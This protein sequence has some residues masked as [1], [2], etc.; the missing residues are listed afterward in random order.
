MTAA[1]KL[2]D[3]LSA[4]GCNPRQTGPSQWS[5]KCPV[6]GDKSPSMSVGVGKDGAVLTCRVGCDVKL[7]VEAVGLQLSDL[8]DQ[9][10]QKGQRR[11]L[12]THDYIDENDELLYQTVRFEGTGDDRFRQ[13]RPDGKG[14][15]IW[16]LKDTRRVLYNLPAV[17][18]AIEAGTVILAAEGEHDADALIRA[19]TVATTNPLGAANWKPEYTAQ[20]AGANV[21]LVIDRDD[22]GRKRA[23][24]LAAE[25]EGAGG[26]TIVGIYEPVE[27]KD[28]AEVL[29]MGYDLDTGFRAVDLDELATEANAQV[30][31]VATPPT[32]KPGFYFKDKVGLLAAK[33]ADDIQAI[34]P[35]AYGVDNI[36]WSYR[37]GVWRPDPR[38]VAHRATTL[39]GDRYRRSHSVNAEDIIRAQTPKITCDP[40]SEV[41]NFRN[42]LYLWQADLLRDHTPDM[43]TTV[44]LSVDW[45][46]DATCPAFDKFLGEVVPED[47]VALVWEAIGYLLYS[48]NPLHR[49]Y[50]LMGA[51]RNGKG[52]L[53]RV[54]GALIGAANY[55]AVSLHSLVNTRFSTANLFGKIANIAGDIDGTYLEST[56]MFKAITGQDQITAE[57]KGRDAFDFTPWAVPMFSANKVPPSADVTQGY[58]SRWLVIPF[59]N[60]FTG[61]EDRHLDARLT[62]KAELQGIAAKAMPALRSL[63]ERGDFQLPASG[64]KARDEFGRRVDQVRMWVDECC[65]LGDAQLFAPRTE[66][67]RYYR[68]NCGLARCAGLDCWCLEVKP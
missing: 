21:A 45:N 42:G 29:A 1:Q 6:H 54:V 31:D 62:T 36:M 5:A 9:P 14:G 40:V 53:L 67:Y 10:R 68:D 61:R 59:P 33:L 22:T 11:I 19:G 39:L 48:G 49:A 2:L 55:T 43:L 65:Y 30:D 56:A 25:L 16:N 15:W 8:F 28:A 34:G 51:G 37:D 18:E 3:A 35:L 46:P 20:L 24:T 38:V 60:D 64:L 13:R 63:L 52:T 32:R 17:R 12:R 41:I 57:H 47:M 27:G 26:C 44:Q 50:M 58:L 7:I 66:L 23:T 4:N